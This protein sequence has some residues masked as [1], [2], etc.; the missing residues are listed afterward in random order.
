MTIIYSMLWKVELSNIGPFK[1]AE[2][3]LKP[4]TI[5]IGKNSVGKSYFLR[6]LWAISSSFP[7]YIEF[8]KRFKEQGGEELRK[9]LR[10]GGRWNKD[11]VI[12]YVQL[13]VNSFTYSIFSGI[14]KRISIIDHNIVSH[15]KEIGNIS[16]TSDI[17]NI[18][19]SIT[20]GRIS[21]SFVY[22]D[23]INIEVTKTFPLG[24]VF[25][26]G[27]KEYDREDGI[28]DENDLDDVL[29]LVLLY[30]FSSILSP[31]FQGDSAILLVDGRAGLTEFLSSPLRSMKIS[32]YLSIVDKEYLT[33]FY[34]L[35]EQFDKGTLKQ[36]IFSDFFE[37]LGFA[38]K[39]IKKSGVKSPYVKMW[40]N[41]LLPLSQAPSGIREAL[42]IALSLSSPGSS[43]VFIEE[44]EV[45]LHPKAQKLMA[46]MIARAVNSE[47]YIF[48]TT[49]SDYLLSSISNLISL[50]SH[51]DKAKELG[52]KDN[53]ILGKDKVVAYLIKSEGDHSKVDQIE[54]T[55]EGIMESE[56]TKVAEELLDERG[57]ILG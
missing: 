15:G 12:R 31:I 30:I 20:K 25:K 50:S 7:D 55:D 18:S 4:L 17:M 46:K 52:F 54:I 6:L 51:P 28:K 35:L 57:N 45:H 14:G 13:Y 9:R 5:F 26:V 38:L 23:I 19:F 53:E 10:S 21:Y 8:E 24:L 49:H 3:E 56:F 47:K 2:I 37:E 40:N 43:T 34:L 11:E 36:E 1:E 41:V 27:S 42:P 16:M 29:G 33:T 44:P 32:D 22:N 39:L 48:I